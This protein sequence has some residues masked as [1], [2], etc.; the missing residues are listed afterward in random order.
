MLLPDQTRIMGQAKFAYCLLRKAFEKQIKTIQEEG[1]KPVETW[2][3]DE[4][5]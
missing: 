4:N 5:N 2:K 3:S 1:I